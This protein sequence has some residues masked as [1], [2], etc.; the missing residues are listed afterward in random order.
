MD[1]AIVHSEIK[2]CYKDKESDIWRRKTFVCS[3][4]VGAAQATEKNRNSK[5]FKRNTEEMLQVIVRRQ[6]QK[7]HPIVQMDPLIRTRIMGFS[8]SFNLG[9]G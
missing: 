4:L 6:S 9:E 1:N 3:H 5:Q 8:L 7:S 2:L